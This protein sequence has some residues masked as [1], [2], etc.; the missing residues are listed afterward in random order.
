MSRVEITNLQAPDEATT[1]AVNATLT[2]WNDALDVGVLGADNFRQEGLDRRSLSSAQHA[3]FETAAFTS[4]GAASASVTSSPGYSAV[5]LNGGATNLETADITPSV[6]CVIVVRASTQ[7]ISDSTAF[8]NQTLLDLR[9]EVSTDAGVSW[10]ATVASDQS[11][12]IK[13]A[14][15][16]VR[17]NAV[18]TL[19]A[20][21]IGAGITRRYRLAFRATPGNVVFKNGTIFAEVYAR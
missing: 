9:I 5:A 10:A 4:S 16:I 6:N 21:E 11:F 18:A 17:L 15:P 7:A 3:I 13:V 19:M 20:K 12:Q 8:A 14:A 1:A 2:S